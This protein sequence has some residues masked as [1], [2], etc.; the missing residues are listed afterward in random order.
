M[1]KSTCSCCSV[2]YDPPAVDSF[3]ML[4]MLFKNRFLSIQIKIYLKEHY[5]LSYLLIS[6]SSAKMKVLSCLLLYLL[7]CL[8]DLTAQCG[9]S[10]D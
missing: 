10:V 9:N 3:F 1:E 6:G 5:A 2:G 8:L 4:H 7:L